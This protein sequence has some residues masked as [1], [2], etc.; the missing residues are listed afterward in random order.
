MTSAVE[1]TILTM[2]SWDPMTVAGEHGVRAPAGWNPGAGCVERSLKV[3]NHL[4]QAV[5]DRARLH[6]G[7]GSGGNL[8]LFWRE[9]RH[10]L[11]AEPSAVRIIA[12]R[13]SQRGFAAS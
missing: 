7:N 6:R 2:Q 8:G 11:Q 4:V 12:A 5:S 10:E 9:G 13:Q 1:K 3:G